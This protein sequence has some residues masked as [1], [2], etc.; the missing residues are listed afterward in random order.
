[1]PPPTPSRKS[2]HAASALAARPRPFT[3]SSM[4]SR[5]RPSSPASSQNPC[6]SSQL[7]SLDVVGAVVERHHLLPADRAIELGVALCVLDHAAAMIVVR[8]AR[9]L[10]LVELVMVEPAT[11][12]DGAVV[13]LDAM[14]ALLDQVSLVAWTTHAQPRSYESA[15]DGGVFRVYQRRHTS[16][17]RRVRSGAPRETARA[18]LARVRPTGVPRGMV[19]GPR[20][21]RSRVR[22][23]GCSAR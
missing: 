14:D 13:H 11:V 6:S 19:R 7:S 15:T 22:R 20:P 18:T 9:G 4:M 5:T 17:R 21:R 3:R 1:M 2:S 8:G 16:Q 23:R 12:A 10:Q